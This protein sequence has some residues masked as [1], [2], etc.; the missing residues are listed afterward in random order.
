VPFGAFVV[1]A[2]PGLAKI[3]GAYA[4]GYIALSITDEK[5]TSAPVKPSSAF[6]LTLEPKEPTVLSLS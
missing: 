4:Y 5:G 6:D 2:A 3:S 1:V